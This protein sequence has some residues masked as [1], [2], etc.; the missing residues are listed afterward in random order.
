MPDS[1]SQGTVGG[2]PSAA[3]SNLSTAAKPPEDNIEEQPKKV[4]GLSRGSLQTVQR[5]QYEYKSYLDKPVVLYILLIL[6]GR[7]YFCQS[8]I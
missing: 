5:E 3:R 7:A 6:R 4:Q 2:F 1:S 8:E